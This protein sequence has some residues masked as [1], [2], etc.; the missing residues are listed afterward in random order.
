VVDGAVLADGFVASRGQKN[1][2]P[3]IKT[4]A[5]MKAIVLVLIPVRVPTGVRVSR[6][7]LIRSLQ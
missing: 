7:S 3:M 5:A 2:A 4:A 1:S 6:S